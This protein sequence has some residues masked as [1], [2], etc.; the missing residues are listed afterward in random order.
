MYETKILSHPDISTDMSAS[1]TS[2]LQYQKIAE[3]CFSSHRM[4]DGQMFMIF[5][6]TTALSTVRP[7]D[8]DYFQ[9]LLIFIGQYL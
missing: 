8:S 5:S 7:T 4:G 2:K 3:K 1:D 6:A 9:P